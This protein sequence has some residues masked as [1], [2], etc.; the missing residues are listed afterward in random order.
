MIGQV[1]IISGH[2]WA[3]RLVQ[4]VTRSAHNHVVIGI[5]NDICVSAEP[6]GAILRPTSYYPDRG[7]RI[8]WSR[9]NLTPDQADAIADWA[10][11]AEGTEYSWIDFVY[12]GIA[13]LLKQ[14][15]PR[16]I[17]ERVASPDRLICSQL[18]DL[19]LQ[20]GGIHLFADQRPYGAVTPADFA[21]VFIDHGWTDQ[22]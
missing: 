1:A 14:H 17:R 2:G 8:T 5:G 16:F 13:S 9:F 11:D 12:A 10:F 6:R 15:T 4:V 7:D 3:A 19:A 20:A 22:A 18:A 21:Q